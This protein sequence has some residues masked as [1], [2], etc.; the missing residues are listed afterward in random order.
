MTHVFFTTTSRSGP[1]NFRFPEE[2]A[3]R[4]GDL[5]S[6]SQSRHDRESDSPEDR[7]MDALAR[8]LGCLGYFE[9][10]PEDPRAA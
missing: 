2:A 3:R 8:E 4:L 9:T 7:R 6:R 1:V 5:R 10:G